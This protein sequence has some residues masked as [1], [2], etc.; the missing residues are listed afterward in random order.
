MT[1]IIIATA[2]GGL[3]PLIVVALIALVWRKGV[4][5][6]VRGWWRRLQR[7]RRERAIGQLKKVVAR[8][9]QLLRS[10]NKT[11]AVDRW[12]YETAL[13]EAHCDRLVLFSNFQLYTHITPSDYKI[14]WA[15]ES[16]VAERTLHKVLQ[17]PLWGMA[18]HPRYVFSYHSGSESFYDAEQRWLELEAACM[19]HS[20]NMQGLPYACPNPRYV[21]YYDSKEPGTNRDTIKKLE[22]CPE[23]CARCWENLH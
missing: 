10:E 2:I 15:L 13:G 12:S 6:G 20:A 21:R 16:L 9:L 17:G 14:A 18:E 8:K 19:R 11:W 4:L 5:P 3:I 1:E 7:H 23:H 22:D